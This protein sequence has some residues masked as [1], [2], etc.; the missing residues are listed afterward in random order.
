MIDPLATMTPDE[1]RKVKA[2]M[3]QEGIWNISE[4]PVVEEMTNLRAEDILAELRK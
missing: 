3:K 2:Q 1:Y 4:H